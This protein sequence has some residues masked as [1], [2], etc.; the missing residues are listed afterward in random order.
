MKTY[1]D[2]GTEKLPTLRVEELEPKIVISSNEVTW[3]AKK[4]WSQK[5]ILTMFLLA[6]FFKKGT[7]QGANMLGCS[8]V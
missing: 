7:Y 2:Y 4:A 5:R 6:M 3:R 8:V 1:V